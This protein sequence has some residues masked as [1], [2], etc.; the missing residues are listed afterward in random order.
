MVRHLYKAKL[1]S[2]RKGGKS[3]NQPTFIYGVFDNPKQAEEFYKATFTE[4]LGYR[5]EV[6]QARLSDLTGNPK[7]NHLFVLISEDRP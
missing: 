3:F 4:P 6:T 7:E 2:P 5:V 1:E